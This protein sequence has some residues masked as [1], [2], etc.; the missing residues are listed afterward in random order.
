MIQGMALSEASRKVVEQQQQGVVTSKAAPSLGLDRLGAQTR[1]KQV[2]NNLSAALTEG[3]GFFSRLGSLLSGVVGWTTG[4]SSDAIKQAVGQSHGFASTGSKVGYIVLSMLLAAL[5]R[6][7]GLL[8]TSTLGAGGGLLGGLLVGQDKAL[9]AIQSAA[10]KAAPSHGLA[11]LADKLVGYAI[12]HEAAATWLD[13]WSG[14]G[15]TIVNAAAH[16]GGLVH[17]KPAASVA[18]AAV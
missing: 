13:P 16:L 2:G 8:E 17:R 11:W 10:W 14:V 12:G 1:L 18:T 15:Q 6:L 9:A 3:K 5:A 7:I 4:K